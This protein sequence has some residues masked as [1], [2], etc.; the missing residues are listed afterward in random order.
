MNL[1]G[2]PSVES[3]LAQPAVR[4]L[5]DGLR[6]EVV[7]QCVRECVAA[8]RDERGKAGAEAP[9]E[10]DAAALV[11]ARVV[12]RLQP[13]TRFALRRVINATG[14][15]IHTNLGRS[16]LGPGGIFHALAEATSGYCNLEVD[17]AT[18]ERSHREAHVA[19]LL[20]RLVG[21]E[22]A[23]V[24]N[25]NA[26][27]VVLTLT[28]LAA[29]QRVVCSRGE[30]V[31]IGGSFRLPEIIACSGAQLVEVGTTNHA[32]V[33]DYEA[34]L[35]PDTAAIL[36]I[37]PSNFRIL[38]FTSEAPLKELA[39]LARRSGTLL[40]FDA[41]SGLL[42]PND[43]PVFANEPVVRQAVA[44]GADIVT[45]STD[46]LLGGPQGGGIVGRRDLL[47]RISRHP[48]KR[49]VRAGK[50]TLAALEAALRAHL[51]PQGP[52]DTVTM[53]LIHRPVADLAR[54]ARRL[55]RA[56]ARVAP[57]WT[58]SIEPDESSIGGGSLPG[59]T[60]PTAVLWLEAPGIAAD[61]LDRAF[62]AHEPPIFGRFRKGRFGLDL[63]TLLPGDRDDIVACISRLA[64]RQSGIE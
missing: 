48:L 31:E 35:T 39:E 15:I 2:I 3:V 41:G 12:E 53:R 18:G 61:A 64:S 58:R 17:V 8:L 5:L 23:T 27:A 57:E 43:E 7:V 49:A 42:L 50:M 19:G 9:P 30:L 13:P 26:A 44:D 60:Q 34:A 56:I 21:A 20:T 45:F 47:Q 29:G 11:A 28:A 63:R 40:V 54:E 55:A 51:Q 32:R 24:V 6:R 38:G 62:R 4:A 37:H 16:P 52:P 33:R 22:A 25:N 36:K 14:V 59:E 46:K 1:L 10:G